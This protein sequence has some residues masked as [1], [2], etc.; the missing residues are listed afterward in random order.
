MASLGSNSGHGRRRGSCVP[1]TSTATHRRFGRIFRSLPITAFDDANLARLVGDGRPDTCGGARIKRRCI[2]RVRYCEPLD[3][4]MPTRYA[5]TPIHQLSRT[6]ARPPLSSAFA[7]SQTRRH[8]IRPAT[9]WV[10]LRPS[11][12][13]GDSSQ[14]ERHVSHRSWRDQFVRRSPARISAGEAQ[15]RCK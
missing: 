5:A 9:A 7:V 1:R 2:R 13:A 14:A 3:Q 4:E 15:G 6:V 8:A 11:L 10:G 12:V